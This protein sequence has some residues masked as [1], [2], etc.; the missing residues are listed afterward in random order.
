M[1]EENSKAVILENNDYASHVKF[2]SSSNLQTTNMNL[3]FMSRSF[4]GVDV[5]WVEDCSF[6]SSQFDNP[7]EL[8][9]RDMFIGKKFLNLQNWLNFLILALSRYASVSYVDCM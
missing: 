2:S 6:L 8:I 9:L 4:S 3:P 1:K 5:E 7:E